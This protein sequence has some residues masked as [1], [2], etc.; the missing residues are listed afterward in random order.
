[1][2]IKDISLLDWLERD[3]GEGAHALTRITLLG[4]ENTVET[5]SDPHDDNQQPL[6]GEL[7]R[8][9][10]D[11]LEH[12]LLNV[13][14]S[15]FPWLI[16]AARRAGGGSPHAYSEPLLQTYLEWIA[17]LLVRAHGTDWRKHPQPYTG[18]NRWDFEMGVQGFCIASTACLASE[19]TKP[20]RALADLG[21]IEWSIFE[22]AHAPEWETAVDHHLTQQ[23]LIM[24]LP[25][26]TLDCARKTVE[27]YRIAS[28]NGAADGMASEMW[29]AMQ[30]L[31]LRGRVY[32]EPPAPPAPQS[33][34]RI[35]SR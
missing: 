17:A 4:F 15:A 33:R 32:V 14:H 6:A 5:L 18:M 26:K 16:R 21:L 30:H 3:A 1:M 25:A 11:G 27:F 31:L 23:S 29:E 13:V 2:D 24:P 35:T 10:E 28:T 9:R 20:Y 22:L 8:A 19:E 7:A 34:R 12:I